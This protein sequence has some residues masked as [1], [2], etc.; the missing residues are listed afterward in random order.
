MA[1]NSILAAY[2]MSQQGRK[3]DPM[4]ARRRY[5][6]QLLQAGSSTAPVQSWGEGLA[7]ALQGGIGAGLNVFNSY[8]QEQTETGNA[9]AMGDALAAKTPEAQAEALKK[10]RGDLAAPIIA[11]LLSQKMELER[12][13]TLG[14]RGY[15][16]A[17]GALPGVMGAMG[18]SAMP[19]QG[20]AGGIPQPGYGASSAPGGIT[21]NNVGNVTNGQGGF[22]QYPTPEAGAQDAAT[23]LQSYPV[24]YNQGQPMTLMQIAE[25]YAPKDDGKDPMLRG[26]DPVAWANNVAKIAGFNPN[27]PLDF[28]NP[29]VLSRVMHGV[30]IHEKGRNNSQQAGVINQGVA[31]AVDPTAFPPQAAPGQPGTIAQPPQ[32][33]QGTDGSGNPPRPTPAQAF[34]PGAEYEALGQRAAQMKDWETATKYQTEA[35]KARATFKAEQYKEQDK[36]GYEATEYDRRQG[37]QRQAEGAEYDRRQVGQNESKLRDDFNN[38]KPVKDHREAAAVFRSA[39]QAAKTNSAAADLNLVYAF[40]KLMD[41]GSVVREGEMGMVT[42]TQNATDRIKALVA[43]VSGGQ[44]ISPD[45]RQALL[46]EMSSRYESYKLAHDEIAGTFKGIAQRQG[47]NPDN[48]VIP[49][50]GVEYE[51]TSPR[52]AGGP[53]PGDVV[54]GWMFKG[55]DPSDQKNWVRQ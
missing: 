40:A 55:G 5:A 47:A 9:A 17:G 50:P 15:A 6:E 25:R 52:Q 3:S 26:N 16:G 31:Q 44:R 23:L 10:V 30:Q 8:Q 20:G 14:Q 51:K 36:R 39:V 1:D 12:K 13:D 43:S 22:R 45:A 34:D 35:N 29:H 48:V 18:P 37:G 33:A 28:M 41:P 11:S 42:A 21:A 7:R 46:Q 53:K 19:P 2:L 54:D 27:E 4:D 32:I 38:L 24:K 49:Y